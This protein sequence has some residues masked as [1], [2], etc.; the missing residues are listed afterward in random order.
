MDNRNY[1]ENFNWEQAKLEEKLK[2]KIDLVRSLIPKD[3]ITIADVGCGNGVISNGLNEHFNVVAFDRSFNALK[4]VKTKK[5]N[6]SA[7]YL[8]IKEHSFDLV[9]SS[10]MIEHLP[11]EVFYKAIEEFKRI[12]K[13]YIFLTFPNDEN[14]EKQLTKCPKCGYEFNKSYH[15]RTLNIDIIKN[16]FPEYKILRTAEYGMKVRDYNKILTKIKHKFTPSN[17]WIPKYWTKNISRETMCPNCGNKFEIPYKFNFFAF[18]IDMLNIL[19]SKK[20]PY[21][22]FILLEKEK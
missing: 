6:A 9:F 14:I 4:Y 1:Y 22:L 5:I 17:S 16:L 19:I 2:D 11:D 7:D 12:S 13:K 3:A 21:Q 15:L 18:M 8:P 10:E 20:R